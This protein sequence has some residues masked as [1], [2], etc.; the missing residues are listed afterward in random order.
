MQEPNKSHY[1]PFYG[2]TYSIVTDSYA[3]V[4]APALES[5][6]VR[7][8]AQTACLLHCLNDGLGA[9]TQ[10]LVSDLVFAQIEAVSILKCPCAG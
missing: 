9:M 8:L 5:F 4:F 10:I 2:E 1:I 7:Y 3:V 6:E